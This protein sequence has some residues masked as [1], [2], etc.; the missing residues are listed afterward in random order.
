M[1]SGLFSAWYCFVYRWAPVAQ[2]LGLITS[3]CSRKELVLFPKGKKR[4]PDTRNQAHSKGCQNGTDHMHLSK[5]CNSIMVNMASSVDLMRMHLLRCCTWRPYSGQSGR[6]RHAALVYMY[7]WY[8]AC[9]CPC[10][11]QSNVMVFAH[12][13]HMTTLWAPVFRPYRDHMVFL[14]GLLTRF[15]LHHR[16]KP[17]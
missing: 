16:L 9:M 14:N 15:W 5:I 7:I 3:H 6:L 1:R 10:H 17:G 11:G 8:W 2:R 13:Y 4:R 12:Q